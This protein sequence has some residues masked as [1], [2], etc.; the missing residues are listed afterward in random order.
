MM[1]CTKKNNK[2]QAFYKHTEKIQQV[3]KEVEYEE[4]HIETIHTHRHPMKEG[5]KANKKR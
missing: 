3:H 1:K 2:M 5:L 4:A